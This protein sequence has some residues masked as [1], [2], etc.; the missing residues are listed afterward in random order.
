MDYFILLVDF[1]STMFTLN[2]LLIYK[3]C[4][5]A[6]NIIKIFPYYDI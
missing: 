5:I 4:G 1:K 2:K 3:V 6:L